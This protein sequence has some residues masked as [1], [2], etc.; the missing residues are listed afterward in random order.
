MS[1]STKTVKSQARQERAA[2]LL[3]QQQ[4][5]E[6]RRNIM[7]VGAVVV[8]MA[9]IV[10]V[11]FFINASRD[12]SDDIDAA[13]AGASEWGL[14]IGDADA[15]HEVVIYEDFLCSYCGQLE[16]ESGEDLNRLAEAG[17][18][19]VEY[20]PFNL[21]DNE[22]SIGAANAFAVLLEESGPE[23]AKKF[24]DLVFEDQPSESSGLPG[25]DWLLEK[26]VEAGADE[27]A[28]KAGIEGLEKQEWVDGATKAAGDAGVNSTPIILLDG[29]VF[30][31]GRTI[32]EMTE[33]LVAELE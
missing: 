27:D 28:V 13:P 3:R 22:Y 7:V 11:L 9:L 32:E 14:T 18:V 10:G 21:L 25:S 33:N 6:R 29:E 4:A 8:A 1:K 16:R 5:A 30:Q 20:R 17:K 2:A 31:D 15:P 24:H 12:S 23:V 19:Q 26:A